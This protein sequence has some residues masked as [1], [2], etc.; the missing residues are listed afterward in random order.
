MIGRR[1]GPAAVLMA[2]MTVALCGCA[3]SSP[4]GNGPPGGGTGGAGANPGS[5][6]TTG[7]GG[8][9]GGGSGG[10]TGAGGAFGTGGSAA[11][12]AADT[13]PNLDGGT[14]DAPADGV[15]A[16]PCRI[17]LIPLSAP[18]LIDV[19]KSDR[20]F[21]VRA[22]VTVP[23]MGDK[24]NWSVAYKN[25][26]PF[27]PRPWANDPAEVAFDISMSGD[28]GILAK[29][30]NH[31]ECGEGPGRLTVIEPRPE[32]FTVRVTPEDSLAL[33]P[34]EFTSTRERLPDGLAMTAQV[35]TIRVYPYTGASTPLPAY[36]QLSSAGSRLTVEGN[37]ARG[38]LNVALAADRQYDLLMIPSSEIAPRLISGTPQKLAADQGFDPGILVSGRALHADNSAVVDARTVLRSGALPSTI[39]RS[40][41]QGDFTLMMREG[42]VAI[43]VAAPPLSGLPDLHVNASAGLV[44]DGNNPMLTLTARWTATAGTLKITVR[45]ADGTTTVPGAAVRAELTA[46]IAQAGQ[47]TAHLDGAPLDSDLQLPATGTMHTEILSDAAGVATFATLPRGAYQVTV[48]PPTGGTSAITTATVDLNAASISREVRLGRLVTLTGTL[49]PA[50]MSKGV[51]ITAID[52]GTDM[53]TPT[54]SALVGDG[55]KYQL[56]LHPGRQYK[57]WA[58]PAAGQPFARAVVT[59]MTPT[60]TQATFADF[61]LPH[62]MAVASKV[63]NTRPVANALVQVFCPESSSSCADPTL[64]IAEAISDVNGAFQ[65]LLP[66]ASGAAASGTRQR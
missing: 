1:H 2:G 13:L 43:D 23:R 62:A 45:A 15:I 12:A 19:E 39:G 52:S 31:P 65:V 59:T 32:V 7:S 24:W 54:V 36:V 5:G 34:Q 42:P 61:T 40:G 6:G 20:P 29:L 64:P 10:S 37:T 4:S 9:F 25:D 55:G 22:T 56:S 33:P 47:L 3:A 17:S 60:N 44:L 51:R 50:A 11:D 14:A 53:V 30:D 35:Q 63:F 57:L 18:S 48:M 21:R 38:P 49:L 28:Y 58:V 27:T 41:A 16:P 46:A 8:F 26:K 66:D